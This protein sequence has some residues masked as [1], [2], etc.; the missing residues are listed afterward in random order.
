MPR[1][2]PRNPRRAHV[3]VVDG[4]AC[5]HVRPE[6]IPGA[7]TLLPRVLCD[8]C[9]AFLRIKKNFLQAA[10]GGCRVSQSSLTSDITCK[11]ASFAC[12][13]I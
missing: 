7:L 3:C 8:A 5:L 13:Q 2:Q 1:H 10:V 9:V 4:T 11:N 6:Q 12:V